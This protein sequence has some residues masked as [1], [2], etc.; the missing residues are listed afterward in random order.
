MSVSMPGNPKPS[1]SRVAACSYPLRGLH[2]FGGRDF[3]LHQPHPHGRADAARA[4]QAE[5][6]V[7]LEPLTIDSSGKRHNFRIELARTDADRARG[8]MFRNP[9]QPIRACSSISSATRWSR[10]GCATPSFARHDLHLRRRA[11]HRIEHRTEVQSE[12][13]ISSGVPVRAVL[14]LNAGTAERLGLKPGDR[15]VHRCSAEGYARLRTMHVR[16]SA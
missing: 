5:G 1:V 16:R 11:H 3:G 7:R 13:T 14:E 9:C 8:L 10:C 4:Q 2:A 15:V 6:G 12:R